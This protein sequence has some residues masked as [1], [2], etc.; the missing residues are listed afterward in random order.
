MKKLLKSPLIALL[1]LGVIIYTAYKLL[2]PE[3]YNMV[4]DAEDE[5][6]P[7]YTRGQDSTAPGAPG[8]PGTPGTAPNTGFNWAEFWFGKDKKFFGLDLGL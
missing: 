2:K 6:S 5:G 4:N 7:G 1:M 3:G 8:S